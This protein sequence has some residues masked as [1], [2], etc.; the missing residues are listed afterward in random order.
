MIEV[1]SRSFLDLCKVQGLLT[2]LAVY[3]ADDIL[4]LV[5]LPYSQTGMFRYGLIGAFLQVLMMFIHVVLLYFD[6]RG[7]VMV[8]SLL[9]L[10]ANT[11]FSLL[12]VKLGFAFYG[13]GFAAACFVG[14]AASV[15][16]LYARVLDLEYITFAKRKIVGQITPGRSQRARP[17]GGYGRYRPLQ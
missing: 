13:A 16:M 4:R 6:L 15:A 1:L 10:A 2:F 12:T 14:L 7:T 3:F 8:L 17:G 9:F 5:N 11:G